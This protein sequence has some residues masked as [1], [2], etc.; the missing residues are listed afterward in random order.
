MFGK[1]AAH[2]G[3][4]S[5]P[6]QAEADV[7]GTEL[8]RAWV[9]GGSFFVSLR[10]EVWKDPA[11]WGIAI[12]DIVRHL[13]DAYQIKQGLDREDTTKRIVGLL[14]A[15]LRSPTDTPTGNFVN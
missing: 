1:R 14:E 13:A 2:K 4:L 5:I 8:L 9:A 11:A 7:S 6:P 15:E 3:E 10:P 12:A